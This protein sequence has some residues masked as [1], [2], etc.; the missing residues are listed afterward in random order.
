MAFNVWVRPPF[1]DILHSLRFVRVFCYLV[2]SISGFSFR[3]LQQVSFDGTIS[4]LSLAFAGVQ[5]ITGLSHR[6]RVWS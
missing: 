2:L 3:S 1:Y 4:Y 6:Y 5:A